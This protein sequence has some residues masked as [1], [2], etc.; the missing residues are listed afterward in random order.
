VHVQLAKC[1]PVGKT[2]TVQAHSTTTV[3]LGCDER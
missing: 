1:I 3:K 2:V